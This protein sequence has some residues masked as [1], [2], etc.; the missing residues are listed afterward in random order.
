MNDHNV[1]QL[2][3]WATA[4][5]AESDTARLDAEVLLCHVLGRD[6]SFLFTWPEHELN[7]QQLSD[8]RQLVNQRQNGTPV[9]YL[10]GE[11]DFWTL[12]LSVSPATLIPR[13]DTEL[14]VEKA[15]EKPLPDNAEVVDLGTGTGAIA[16]ALASEKPGW[17][18]VAVD[19]FADAVELARKNAGLNRISNVEILQGNWFE[20]LADR[21]FHLVVSNPPYICND[22]EHLS[23]GDV[24]FEP[25]TALTSGQDG[26]DDIRIIIDQA[27]EHLA[28]GGWLL[29][30]HGYHQANRIQQLLQA[31]GYKDIRTIKDWAGHDRVTEGQLQ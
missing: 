26:L 2:L 31:A 10:T 19:M 28:P 20:P 6:R 11:R 27:R 14:L 25:S 30:E 15:L 8:F 7:E 13:P 17:S 12:K 1:D 4:T 9:A 18:V 21:K 29:I 23:Q 24:R 3:S 22:D 5:L 16:L